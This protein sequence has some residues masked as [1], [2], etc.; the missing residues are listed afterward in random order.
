MLK[1]VQGD[2]NLKKK[3]SSLIKKITNRCGTKFPNTGAF[4]TSTVP[5]LW[6]FS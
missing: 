1:Y 4:D 5:T 6:P 2:N 3:L